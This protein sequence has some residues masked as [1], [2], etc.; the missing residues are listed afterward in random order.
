MEGFLNN[1]NSKSFWKEW[2]KLTKKHKDSTPVIKETS[3]GKK[4]CEC[5]AEYF[6]N[7]FS[8]STMNAKLTDEFLELYSNTRSTDELLY[9]TIEQIEQAVKSLKLGSALD[10]FGLSVEYILFSHPVIYLHSEALFNASM[11]HDYISQ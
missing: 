4:P 10:V 1:N 6:S 8:D 11:Y 9:F 2:K 7:K 3:N 5:F